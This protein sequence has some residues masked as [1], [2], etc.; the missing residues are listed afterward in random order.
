LK[1][2]ASN[3]TSPAS[4]SPVR[5]GLDV[6]CEGAGVVIYSPVVDAEEE[7]PGL[8]GGGGEICA[9]HEWRSSGNADDPTDQRGMVSGAR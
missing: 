8:P 6:C 1:S 2:W 7:K 3:T 5:F 4:A 9:D